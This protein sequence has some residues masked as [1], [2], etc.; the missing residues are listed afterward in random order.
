MN[1]IKRFNEDV[2]PIANISEKLMLWNNDKCMDEVMNS[3]KKY[4]TDPS[5][6]YDDLRNIIQA[7]IVNYKGK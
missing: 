6:D 2:D 3:I 4:Y 5:I 7:T 1:Y